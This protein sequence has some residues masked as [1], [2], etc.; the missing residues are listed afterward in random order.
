MPEEIVNLKNGLRARS[1][2]HAA[3]ALL[4]TV[5]A[6]VVKHPP[7]QDLPFHMA[8]INVLAHI[9]DPAWGYG[10]IYELTLGRT[11][12]L[13]YYGLAVLLSKAVGVYFANLLL[14]CVYL[15]GTPLAVAYVLRGLGVDTRAAWFSVPLLYNVM[16][17]FGLLPFVFGIPVGIFAIG[18]A[19]RDLRAPSRKHGVALAVTALALFYVHIFPFGLFGLAYAALFPWAKPRAYVRA[20]APMLPVGAAVGYWSLFTLAGRTAVGLDA[21]NV[22]DPVLPAREA[23]EQIWMWLGDTFHDQSDLLVWKLVAGW[24]IA[25][26]A[27]AL[28]TNKDARRGYKLTLLC[29][30]CAVLYFVTPQSRGPIYWLYS[31]RFPVL[32]VMCAAMLVRLPAGRLGHIAAA[33]GWLVSGFA[34][35][36]TCDHYIAFE[37]KEVGDID[38]AIDALPPGKRV[39]ALIFDKGSNVVGGVPFLHMGSYYQ[40]SK[41][42]LIQFSYAGYDHWPFDYKPG[43]APPPGKRAPLRW[44]WMPE[45]VSVTRELLPFYDYVLTRGRGFSP[46]PR[47]YVAEGTFDRWTVWRR[48]PHAE[49]H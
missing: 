21:Q 36:Q 24:A 12:Y 39:A 37:T 2:L 33:A 46:P 11:Q 15:A 17:Q 23:Y 18:L 27:V 1:A 13:V 30:A 5:P 34:V 9:G 25:V 7:L 16:W 20:V 19:L 43:K 35:W 45:N 10:D 8:T 49:S 48:E 44:E 41:P 38:G 40:A 14:M 42:G 31:Q 6:W 47:S 26:T 29:A 28:A 4:A 22:K 3:Y 32:F